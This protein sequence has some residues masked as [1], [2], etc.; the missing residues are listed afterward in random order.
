MDFDDMFK[1]FVR[2]WFVWVAICIVG[3]STALYFVIQALNKYV[4]G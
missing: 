4:N 3:G 1:W 2:M